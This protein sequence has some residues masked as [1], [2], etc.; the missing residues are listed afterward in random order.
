MKFRL[1]WVLDHEGNLFRGFPFYIS[2]FFN[3]RL[4]YADFDSLIIEK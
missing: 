2:S 1:D 3:W 4:A